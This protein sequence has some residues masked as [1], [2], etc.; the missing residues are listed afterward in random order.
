RILGGL[1]LECAELRHR[2]RL[3]ACQL[4]DRPI[5]LHD[6]RTP[7][8]RLTNVRC[9]G[10][11]ADRLAVAGSLLLRRLRAR[12]PVDLTGAQID[13]DRAC[14]GADLRAAGPAAGSGADVA[15]GGGTVGAAD[16]VA[17]DAEGARVGGYV[18]M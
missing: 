18:L 11:A 8:I 4:G 9:G 13:G 5:V 12:G 16:R 17:L 15:A 1:D 10:L 2:L 3:T 14:Q 6:A 7:T